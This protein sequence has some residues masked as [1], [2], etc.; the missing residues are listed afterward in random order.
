MRSVRRFREPKAFLAHAEPFLRVA[1]VENALM[2]GI[3]GSAHFDDSCYLATV[4]EDGAVVACALRTPPHSALLTRADR[5]ALES[6]VTDL[7]NKYRSLPTVAGPEPAAGDFAQLWAARTGVTARPPV[8]MRVFEACRV[9]PPP[10]PPGAFRAATEA[11]LPTLAWWT[12]AFID[13]AGL[14]ELSD[15]EDITRERIREGSLFVWEDE[16]PVS[17]AAW[18]G[19]TG[20]VARVNYVYTPPE[21]RGHGYASACVATLT[22]QLLDEGVPRCCLYTDLSNPT[23]N[24]IY[25]AIGYRPVCDAAEYRLGAVPLLRPVSAFDLAAIDRWASGVAESMSR[26]RPLAAA[27]DRNDPAA[28]LYWYVIAEDGRDVGTVWIELLPAASEAILGIFL[29]DPEDRGRGVG[30][31]AIGLAVAEFRRAH[32]QT[33][34][35]LRVRRTNARAIACY[36]RAGFA[37][38][39]SGSKTLPSGEV[40]PYYR[41]VLRPEA[42]TR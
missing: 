31:A 36:R 15:P 41:M 14:G 25:Q 32:A 11:D 1:E 20:R 40:V 19:R 39:G 42:P 18:A 35:A 3:C 22:Q 38:T 10:T 17:M 28:G 29:G 8:R 2:L 24:K 5:P 4:E 16:R 27:A 13:E 33:P 6:L 37:V 23:S 34:I 30:S 7:A 21:R 12:A 26:T 9:I